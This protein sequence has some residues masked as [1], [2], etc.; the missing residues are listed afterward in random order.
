[1]GF[2]RTEAPREPVEA[3]QR[4]GIAICLLNAVGQHGK[5]GGKSAIFVPIHERAHFAADGD[6]CQVEHLV[7]HHVLDPWSPCPATHVHECHLVQ[8]HARLGLLGTATCEAKHIVHHDARGVQRAEGFAVPVR[9]SFLLQSKHGLTLAE[10][11]DVP[12]PGLQWP[13]GRDGKMR[14]RSKHGGE[15]TRRERGRDRADAS[16]I[17]VSLEPRPN[18]P[19]HRVRRLCPARRKGYVLIDIEYHNSPRVRCPKKKE[20]RGLVLK[21]RFRAAKAKCS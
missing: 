2:M 17:V 8:V 12:G 19:F 13:C 9:K 1:M 10:R 6:E 15:A 3:N 16:P 4:L 7:I 21:P 5:T 20:S 14:V 11:V 18:L